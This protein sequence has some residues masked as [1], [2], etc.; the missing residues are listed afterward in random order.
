MISG[1]IAPNELSW[2][3][4]PSFFCETFLSSKLL[5]YFLFSGNV[6][7]FVLVMNFLPYPWIELLEVFKFDRNPQQASNYWLQEAKCSNL[8]HSPPDFDQLLLYLSS[9][10]PFI[11][12][13][14]NKLIL[15]PTLSH[16]LPRIQRLFLDFLSRNYNHFLQTTINAVTNHMKY[17]HEQDRSFFISLLMTSSALNCDV[18]ND[19]TTVSCDASG[20][21]ARHKT[22]SKKRKSDQV[23]EELPQSKKV[24]VV[25]E[26][27][28][29]QAKKLAAA[30]SSE[31]CDAIITL[32]ESMS[33][34]S[35]ERSFGQ[36]T[37]NEKLLAQ[38]GS[39]LCD[40]K[41]VVPLA[42]FFKFPCVGF[43]RSMTKPASR[44]LLLVFAQLSKQHPQMLVQS[45]FPCLITSLTSLSNVQVAFI[46]ALAKQ[47]LKEKDQLTLFH[48]ILANEQWSDV[49]LE[50]LV[51]LH[52]GFLN[53]LS[54]L[55]VKVVSLL[56]GFFQSR[57]VLGSKLFSFAKLLLTFLKKHGTSLSR[58]QV[59][60]LRGVVEWNDTA[61]KSACMAVLTKLK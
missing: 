47:S 40:S 45:F 42:V 52:H 34:T 55:N 58:D 3:C 39:K 46:I 1:C 11:D 30:V 38:V 48:Q 9:P 7:I 14:A 27:A 49:K 37:I 19:V 60:S 36:V 54:S 20:D 13:V 8:Y 29:D 22:E 21:I 35:L 24:K 12:S 51:S 26:V 16:F 25:N 5:K 17:Y 57:S 43:A 10:T 18:R 6:L 44:Q 50:I 32:M 2:I 56:C 61:L 28:D 41:H 23:A 53:F 59:M 15:K 31:E 33:E 4:R